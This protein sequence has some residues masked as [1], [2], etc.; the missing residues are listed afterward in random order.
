MEPCVCPNFLSF[1]GPYLVDAK[2]IVVT[3][4][5]STTSVQCRSGNGAGH[6]GG[7]REACLLHILRPLDGQPAEEIVT[8]EQG[9]VDDGTLLREAGSQLQQIRLL[10]HHI[11]HVQ[12]NVIAVAHFALKLGLLLLLLLRQLL[13]L[14]LRL[15][16]DDPLDQ[17]SQGEQQL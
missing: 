17:L 14:K 4:T 11:G 7:K 8:G 16:L 13:R 5:I 2:C 6:G 12:G 10:L 15:P 9:G 3:S 1:G